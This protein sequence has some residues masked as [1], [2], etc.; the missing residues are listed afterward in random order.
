MTTE[1]LQ[2][3]IL[4]INSLSLTNK[5]KFGQMNAHQM[6]VHCADQF[7][8]TKGEIETEYGKVDPQEIIAKAK[9]R[10]TVQAPKGLDQVKG[11]G[12]PLTTFENDKTILIDLMKE[13][14]E[15]PDHDTLS[16]HPYLGAKDK[17]GWSQLV[18]YHL[19]H[20]LSQFRA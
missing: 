5:P 11:E 8:L 15:R 10:I 18:V 16:D 17:S 4:R 9:A 7:R 13:F 2:D 12:T 1:Q 6:I 20:H 19:N 14:I 3:F